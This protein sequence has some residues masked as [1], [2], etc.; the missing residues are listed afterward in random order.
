LTALVQ[1]GLAIAAFA[2]AP[3]TMEDRYRAAQVSGAVS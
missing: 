3:H 1:A 2:P